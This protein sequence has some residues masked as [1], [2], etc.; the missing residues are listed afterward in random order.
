VSDNKSVTSLLDQLRRG[1]QQVRSELLNLVY[2]ELR[3]LA[4]HYMKSERP[5]HTLQATAVVHELYIR[6]LGSEKVVWQNRAH[7]MAVAAQQMRHILVDH[8]RA[9]CTEKRGGNLFNVAL[10]DAKVVG[11]M[12][13]ENLLALDEA[14]TRLES[15]DSTAGR[16]V[17]MR[18]F[19]GLT[20]KETGEALN[21]SVSSVKRKW[22]FARAWLFDQLSSP[23]TIAPD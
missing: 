21:M 10:E 2:P 6:M 7:F 16:L 5:G 19:G 9:R 11:S 22:E 1:N 23:A 3:K 8:A 18:F 4:Q 17:E 15:L 20:E 12:R 13:D 14:L